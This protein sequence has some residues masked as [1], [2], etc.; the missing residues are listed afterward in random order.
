MILAVKIYTDFNPY[1]SESSPDYLYDLYGARV[2][3]CEVDTEAEAFFEMRRYLEVNNIYSD[4][5]SIGYFSEE[6]KD[7]VSQRVKAICMF[8][9]YHYNKDG[10]Y[11]GTID[12]VSFLLKSDNSHCLETLEDFMSH[13]PKYTREACFANS[14]GRKRN[15]ET[16]WWGDD[17]KRY[18]DDYKL[19]K[20]DRLN[21]VLG[22][23][24]GKAGNEECL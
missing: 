24:L 6:D 2:V 15:G 23:T 11:D 9:Q 19:R 7:G 1:R 14:P 3:L 22:D 20:I 4:C 17:I 21:S 5:T 18:L 13:Y 16:V 10:Y 8:D 12:N